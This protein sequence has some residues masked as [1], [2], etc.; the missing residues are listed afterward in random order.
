MR[1]VL[2]PNGASKSGCDDWVLNADG[3]EYVVDSASHSEKV[4]PRFARIWLASRKCRDV[5]EDHMKHLSELGYQPFSR[6]YRQT[7]PLP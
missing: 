2:L 1:E 3:E 6:K 7:S 5:S 4:K